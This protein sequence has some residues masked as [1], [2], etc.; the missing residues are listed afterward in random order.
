VLKGTAI[1]LTARLPILLG[2]LSITAYY[3]VYNAVSIT[4][5]SGIKYHGYAHSKQMSGM[6]NNLDIY[7]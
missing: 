1:A 4:E 7:S 5:H 3:C 2:H 6:N